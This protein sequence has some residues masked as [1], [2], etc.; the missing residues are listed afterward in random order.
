MS[1]LLPDKFAR[2]GWRGREDTGYPRNLIGQK[3]MTSQYPTSHILFRFYQQ[4][5]TRR[6]Y[7][8]CTV[9]QQSFG[10]IN[11]LLKQAARGAAS[12]RK[13]M[14]GDD[15]ELKIASSD[16]DDVTL[17]KITTTFTE[18]TPARK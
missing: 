14:E 1:F 10:G 18:R 5:D 8:L 11:L 15:V 16:D 7:I 9:N 17:L 2:G 6:S 13:H 3:M 12:K 4:T